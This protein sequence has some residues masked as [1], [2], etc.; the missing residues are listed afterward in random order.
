MQTKRRERGSARVGYLERS[1]ARTETAARR[2]E[3]QECGIEEKLQ[4][5]QCDAMRCD[6]MRPRSRVW[7]G[8]TARRRRRRSAAAAAAAAAERLNVYRPSFPSAPLLLRP[9]FQPSGTFPP[10]PPSFILFLPSFPFCLNGSGQYHGSHHQLPWGRS[11][12]KIIFL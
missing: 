6:A 1:T 10:C 4:Q 5:Q 12:L 8:G 2:R 9:P 11:I 3:E 7:R